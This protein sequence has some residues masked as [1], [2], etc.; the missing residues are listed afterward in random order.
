M[1]TKDLVQFDWKMADSQEEPIFI[2]I[3]SNSSVVPDT[4]GGLTGIFDCGMSTE[5][6][7]LY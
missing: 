3:D 6:A 5:K 7:F 2:I 1:N 4:A